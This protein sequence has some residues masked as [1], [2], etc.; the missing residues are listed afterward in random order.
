MESALGDAKR[1]QSP[2]RATLDSLGAEALFLLH[3]RKHA[4]RR[5]VG[6]LPKLGGNGGGDEDDSSMEEIGV[7]GCDAASEVVRLAGLCARRRHGW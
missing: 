7:G 2:F 5:I 1:V 4:A 6:A 3:T